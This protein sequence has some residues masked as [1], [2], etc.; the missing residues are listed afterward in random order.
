MPSY[1][2]TLHCCFG[3]ISFWRLFW[4]SLTSLNSQSWPS[5]HLGIETDEVLRNKPT[6]NW[7]IDKTCK[8]LYKVRNKSYKNHFFKIPS[9][10]WDVIILNQLLKSLHRCWVA[11]LRRHRLVTCQP[12]SACWPWSPCM[13]SILWEE[14]SLRRKQ[15]ERWEIGAVFFPFSLNQPKINHCWL[16]WKLSPSV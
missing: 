8:R 16:P 14:N 2:R 13:E 4:I 15:D 1:Y 12:S 9:I 7:N 3:S 10:H 6:R 5:L 11:H